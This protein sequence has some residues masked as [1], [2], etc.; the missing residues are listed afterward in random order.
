MFQDAIAEF[1]EWWAEVR[2]DIAA[3]VADGALS[4]DFI[5]EIG[6]RIWQIHPELEWQLTGGV[7]ATN[8]LN[9]VS[10]GSRL[11]RLVAELWRR[12]GPPADAAWERLRS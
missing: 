7:E 5:D 10:G 12:L 4:D 3:E 2:D 1:W 6:D 8:S 11:L 9:L